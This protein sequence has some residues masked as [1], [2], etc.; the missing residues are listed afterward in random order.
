MF[1][2]GLKFELISFRSFNISSLKI[3]TEGLISVTFW[4]SRVVKY[5]R[6]KFQRGKK[7][8]H[9]I[10]RGKVKRNKEDAHNA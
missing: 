2:K 5:N 8:I 3:L 7:N 4:I 10:N 6:N 1:K 9:C